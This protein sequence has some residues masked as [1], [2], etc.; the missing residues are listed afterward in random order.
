M[1]PLC[2]VLQR[3]LHHSLGPICG[4]ELRGQRRACAE[5]M[6]GCMEGTQQ[7]VLRS[8]CCRLQH[9]ICGAPKQWVLSGCDSKWISRVYRMCYRTRSSS[10]CREG[11]WGGRGRRWAPQ[12]TDI[13]RQSVP[14]CPPG[15]GIVQTYTYGVNACG[16]RPGGCP[17]PTRPLARGTGPRTYNV[18]HRDCCGKRCLALGAVCVETEMRGGTRRKMG[19]ARPP[20]QPLLT[21]V[22]NLLCYIYLP[23]SPTFL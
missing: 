8:A 7:G 18:I 12:C 11:P 13:A 3:L 2:K 22:R 9:T 15:R 21:C 10:T 20:E 5:E 16:V 6:R 17:G 1:H 4:A 23:P 19:P 14:V